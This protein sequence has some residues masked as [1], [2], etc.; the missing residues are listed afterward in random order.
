MYILG[1]AVISG[2]MSV[3]GLRVYVY[4]VMSVRLPLLL[5]GYFFS[6]NF[7]NVGYKVLILGVLP[8]PVFFVK[9]CGNVM[10]LYYIIL[11]GYLNFLV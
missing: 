4:V 7:V 11:F 3:I 6:M 10:V 8:L 1:V 9:V 5:I 2:L